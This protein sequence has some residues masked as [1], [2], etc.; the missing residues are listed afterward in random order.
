MV[1]ATE[2]KTIQKVVQ[3]A[4]TLTD[5]ALRNGSI[6]KNLEKR[7]NEGEPSKDRNVRDDHKR[8]R[9][10]NA[11]ATTTNHVGRENMGTVPKCT[12]CNTHHLPEAPC[13]TCFNC[14]RPRNFARDCRVAP[15]NVN[16]NPV[17]ARNPTAR[18][19][20]ECGGTDHIKSACFSLIRAQGSGENRPN[21]ALANNGEPSDL[22]FSYEI[23]IASGQLVEIDKVIR[24]CK[25]E[26]EGH[27][28][29][30]NL[31]PF[32]SE[33]FDVIIGMD[34]FSGHQAK[35]ICHEKVAKEKKQEEIVV[36]RDFPEVFLDDLSELLPVWEIKFRIELIPRA[37]PVAKS[38][39]RLAPSELE[40]LS[41]QLK[42]LQDKGFIRPR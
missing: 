29:D 7:G 2:P 26:I 37:T 15:R 19:C 31:I 27:M 20:C 4:G 16:V 21:L 36:V 24:G 23:E 42:E 5:E 3:L 12:T 22:G 11:F 34:W 8:T 30:I 41:R 28:F 32:G 17:N 6:K 35:I 33:S 40:E 38:P 25:L 18:E 10:G 13:R 1:T 14:N 39:C 9:M